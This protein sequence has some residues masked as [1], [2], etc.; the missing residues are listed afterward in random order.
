MDKIQKLFNKKLNE[1]IV[2]ITKQFDEFFEKCAEYEVSIG[3]RDLVILSYEE[4][5][6]LELIIHFNIILLVE[7]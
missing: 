3:T 4:I 2:K 1:N 6:N 7:S 5:L